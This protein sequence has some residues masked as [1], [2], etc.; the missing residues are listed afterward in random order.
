MREGIALWEIL[1]EGAG[2]RAAALDDLSRHRLIRNLI[3]MEVTDLV[4]ATDLRLSKSGVCSVEELQRLSY[5]VIGFSEDMHRRNR[6]LKDFL[7]ANLY[8]HYRVVR[9]AVKA[10]RIVSDLFHA[11]LHEPEILPRHVQSTIAERGLERTVCDYTAGMTDRFAMDEHQKLFD[12][13]VIP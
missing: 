6:Q 3:G 2:W 5:N 7:Y 12:P 1:V 4:H 9:M 13:S 11:Y 10:E 8:R